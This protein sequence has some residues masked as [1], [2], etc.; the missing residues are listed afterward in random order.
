M[1]TKLSKPQH[2]KQLRAVKVGDLI[3]AEDDALPEPFACLC[4]EAA[5]GEQ[6]PKF[7]KQYGTEFSERPQELLTQRWRFVARVN[8]LQGI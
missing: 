6:G 2:Y 3:A 4:V 5:R 7:L 1:I 8:F